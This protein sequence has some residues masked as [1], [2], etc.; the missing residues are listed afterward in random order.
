MS[1]VYHNY[2]ERQSY[3]LSSNSINS[4]ADETVISHDLLVTGNVSISG[5][6]VV[7]GSVLF[8]DLDLTGDLGVTG[9]ITGDYLI[10]DTCVL[11]DIITEKTLDNGVIIDSI[12]LREDTLITPAMT[13]A[14]LEAVGSETDISIAL[15]PKGTGAIISDTPDNAVAGGNQRG[16]NAVDLQQIRTVADQVASGNQSCVL[17]GSSN[18]ATDT[19]TSVSG[20]CLNTASATNA[21]VSGGSGN[22]SSGANSCALGGVTNTASGAQ[23]SVC[24]G[25]TNSASDACSF[26]GG[27]C[28]NAASDVNASVL[29]GISNTA[30]GA[31]SSVCGG[32]SCNA[33]GDNSTISGGQSCNATGTASS[34]LGGVSNTASNTNATTCGGTNNTAS[35]QNSFVGGGSGNSATSL[36]ST[37]SGGLNNTNSANQATISGG[38][39]CTNS[40]VNATIGGGTLNTIPVFSTAATICGGESNN[41]SGIAS[42]VT[43]GRTNTASGDL[44]IV[45]GGINNTASGH[46][47]IAAGN[48]AKAIHQGSCVFAD[49]TAADF[50]STATDQF[51]SRFSGGY[52][53]MGGSVEIDTVANDNTEDK[54]LT[55]NSTSKDVEYRDV[56][57]LP[58]PAELWG[59]I[60]TDVNGLTTT[61]SVQG[62]LVI[63]NAVTTL[64]TSSDFDMPV[65]GRLRYTGST[66]YTFM[67]QANA[68]VDVIGISTLTCVQIK[69]LLNGVTPI[70]GCTSYTCTSVGNGNKSLGCQGFVTLATNDY[71]DFMVT[72]NS[73][74]DNLNV[75]A[76]NLT[77]NRM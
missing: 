11:S 46:Y 45:L 59:G 17:G 27:G 63:T 42:S 5:G 7:T 58:L 30:S 20:G 34:I 29:G 48:R 53:F 44:S 9:N 10:A 21:A 39:G 38:E 16:D 43:G 24:G 1:Q 40:G 70:P 13:L 22:T 35:G 18:K 57:S 68:T 75:Y 77:C 52:K 61:I 50:S 12:R 32:Q 76:Y 72:N 14:S 55:W 4:A 65:N 33:T 56:S 60:N 19:C 71:I 36:N 6:L 64:D 49:F 8:D 31:Q 47:S 66:S 2:Y 28:F 69:P 25:G 73:N 51:S 62:T 23:S 26:V 67:V 3:P 41:S 37:I 15:I 54:L 74:T